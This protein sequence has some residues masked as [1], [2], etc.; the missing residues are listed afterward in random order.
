[1]VFMV[2]ARLKMVSAACGYTSSAQR[3]FVLPDTGFARAGMRPF[4]SP[5]SGL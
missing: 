5:I 2:L 1:L 4:T 3:C